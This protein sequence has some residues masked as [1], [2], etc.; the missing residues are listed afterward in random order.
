MVT[1]DGALVQS[2]RPAGEK[3]GVLAWSLFVVLERNRAPWQY[4]VGSDA[5]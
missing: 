3:P 5:R 2:L 1:V 4:R